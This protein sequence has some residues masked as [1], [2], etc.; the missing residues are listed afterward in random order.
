MIV[1]TASELGQKTIAEGVETEET[2]AILRQLGVDY[3][4]GYHVGRPAPVTGLPAPA[5]SAAAAG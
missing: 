1:R 5:V 4:Q 2:M 3:A